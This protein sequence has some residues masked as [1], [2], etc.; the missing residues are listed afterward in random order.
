MSSSVSRRPDIERG[1][2][3]EGERER[4]RERSGRPVRT[5]A[6]KLV[7]LRKAAADT[8]S[9]AVSPSGERCTPCSTESRGAAVATPDPQAP[10]R[11]APQMIRGSRMGR[12]LSVPVTPGLGGAAVTGRG[13]SIVSS[14]CV[15]HSLSRA[16]SLGGC[17]RN[18]D[19]LPAGPCERRLWTKKCP[20]SK[21][22]SR[23][24]TEGHSAPRQRPRR[25]CRVGPRAGPAQL[26]N[27]KG[28]MLGQSHDHRGLSLRRNV[29]AAAAAL[30]SIL[31]VALPEDWLAGSFRMRP[32]C[33]PVLFIEA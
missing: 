27:R 22:S 7:F 19:V 9:L 6:M 20:V 30:R 21:V 31:A 11:V 33:M 3:R 25:C 1:R 17:C 5:F 15:T 2:E 23:A 13:T 26:E 29:D 4:G 10:A 32:R 8:K 12:G 18:R 16:P 24:T 28:D 14:Q